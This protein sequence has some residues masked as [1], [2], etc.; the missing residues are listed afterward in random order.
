MNSEPMQA[1]LHF[2]IR[3]VRGTFGGYFL[4][5]VL[6]ILGGIVGDLT[7]MPGTNFIIGIGMGAGVGYV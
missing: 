4:G 5:F 1:D 6:I 7:G 2:F 3:W